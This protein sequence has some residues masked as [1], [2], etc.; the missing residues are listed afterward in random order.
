MYLEKAIVAKQELD[1][2]RPFDKVLEE[3]VMQKMR[4]DW[5]YHS[6]SIEG[7]SLT[8][9][10]TKS[11]ILHHIT[12]QG[13]P[14]RDHF[15]IT[16]HNEALL[17]IIDLIQGTRTI[18]EN[19]IRELHLLILKENYNKP[20][21]T[22]TGE[23]TFKQIKVGEY[24]TQPNHV[25][26]ITGELFYF[27]EPHDV[28]SKM[29]D[30]LDWYSLKEKEQSIN[31]IIL[32]AEFHYK[33]ILIH[34]FDDGNGRIARILMNFI[35]M[36]FGYHPA[37]IKK[38]KKETYY[39][40][41]RLADSNNIEPFIEFIS[42]SVLESLT[43]M[44]NAI[45][46]LPFEDNN[47]IDKQFWLLDQKIKELGVGLKENKSEKNIRK[48]I[49]TIILPINNEFKRQNSKFEKF[50]NNIFE[51]FFVFEP[52]S[53]E[54]SIN[55]INIKEKEKNLLNVELIFDVEKMKLQYSFITFNRKIN[56][57]FNY[58]Y[59]IYFNLKK[60]GYEINSEGLIVEL[61]YSEN[62]TND[63]IKKIVN[64]ITQDHIKFIEQKISNNK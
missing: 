5:N 25:K 36:K 60:N 11:L 38:E 57:E 7:N 21:Q 29:S 8:F 63:Q 1:S 27:A 42:E 49:N 64:K 31:P 62:L 46:G 43:L 58:E 39:K 50:Y 17:W 2:L 13:K 54:E 32:A 10:E 51:K 56:Q 9:G 20:A 47:D 61:N 15:E 41:L 55:G 16:G 40:V 35:L 44:M 37:I 6:N 53:L 19:F 3:R 22:P 52:I 34:P 33:F 24:K 18:S 23:Q 12:A 48:I 26:T 14:L 4:L 28:K 45:N 30:L 59:N